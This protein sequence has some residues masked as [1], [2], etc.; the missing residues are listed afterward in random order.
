M[1]FEEAQ[2]RVKI[3]HF[4]RKGH[5]IRGVVHVGANDGYE[6]QFY[7][8][9]GAQ[10]VIAFEPLANAMTAMFQKY[11]ND[12]RV[13]LYNC[14]L[15]ERDGWCELAITP[16][17]GQGS[18]FLPEVDPPTY[19]TVGV[20]MCAI[21]RFDSLGI[22]IHP[23]NTLVVDVQGMELQTLHGFGDQLGKFDFLNIECSRVPIYQGGVPA[24]EVIAFLSEHGFDQDSPIEDHDDIFFI[25]KGLASAAFC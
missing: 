3:S 21:H 19:Q 16:G 18:S 1:T 2:D 25:R 5:K 4:T 11:G 7:L 10:R 14:A 17:D 13:E 12:D 22:D 24:S 15:G 6:I 23:C 9:L 8:V 20:Q